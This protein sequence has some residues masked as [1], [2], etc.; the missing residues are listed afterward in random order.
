LLQSASH[1]IWSLDPAT[2]TV[3]A[4]CST[5][6]GTVAPYVLAASSENIY[7]VVDD[8]VFGLLSNGTTSIG[9]FALGGSTWTASNLSG[10]F[11]QGW[12]LI[13][14]RTGSAW[15]VHEGTNGA[16]SVSALSNIMNVATDGQSFAVSLSAGTSNYVHRIVPG[17]WVLNTAP[18][19]SSTLPGTALPVGV[20]NANVAWVD[21]IAITGP[22][23]LHY[24]TISNGTCADSVDSL[25]FGAVPNGSTVVGIADND[26]ALVVPSIQ[27][28]AVSFELIQEPDGTPLA[29][30]M[31]GQIGSSSSALNFV[32]G[33]NHA[34]L[35]SGARP[36]LVSF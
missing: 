27:G 5:P 19:R 25:Q 22:Y 24:T 8:K 14:E 26:Y 6:T 36:V 31:T 7:V 3:S 11:A 32:V 33:G 20:S 35:V 18:C 12:L 15:V 1:E 16:T 34:V 4:L 17:T 29:G 13:G 2:G 10:A 23:Y 21:V 28:G 30:T 9:P